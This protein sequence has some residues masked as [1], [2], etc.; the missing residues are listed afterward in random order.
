MSFSARL[1]QMQ[2]FLPDSNV[3]SQ[4]MQKFL[5]SFQQLHSKNSQVSFLLNLHYKET[6]GC[7]EAA[8][9]NRYSRQAVCLTPTLSKQS[10]QPVTEPSVHRPVASAAPLYC[11]LKYRCCCESS[12]DE[13]HLVRQ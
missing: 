2:T 6:R 3:P 7:F 12:G 1:K 11:M 10:L 4:T 13:M 5:L 8:E 9:L